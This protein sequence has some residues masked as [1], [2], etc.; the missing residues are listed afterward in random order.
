MQVIK[1]FS[2]KQ[3]DGGS[4]NIHKFYVSTEDEAKKWVAKNKYDTYH[5]VTFTVYDTLKE[6]AAKNKD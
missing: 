1:C 6:A 3:W 2:I 4:S 5:E